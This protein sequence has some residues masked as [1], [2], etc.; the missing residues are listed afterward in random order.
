V[1]LPILSGVYADNASVD[2]RTSYPRN[3][4]PVLSSQG[5]S[6]GYLRPADGVVQWG[7]GPGLSRGG[8]NW[9]GECFRVM[10]TKL[11]RVNSSGGHT[12]IGD[13][14]SG[15]RCS[16]AYSFDR[17]AVASGG[18]LYYWNGQTLTQV[19]D[20]DLGQVLDVTYV[21]GYFMT[22][23]GEFL[24][25]T[26]LNDPTAVD[27]LK[28]GSAELDADPVVRV[29]KVRNEAHAVGRYTTEVYT[30]LGNPG[31]PFIRNE[32]AQIHR[33]A[34]GTHAAIVFDADKIAFLGGGLNEPPAI[35]F[36]GGGTSQKVSTREIDTLLQD[37]TEAQLAAAVLEER[38]D[39]SHKLLLVHLQD[40]TLAFDA[41]AS[42]EAGQAIW[43]TL[44]SGVAEP[45][46][47]RARDLV[48]CFDKWLVADPT[49]TA[50]GY[51]SDT[52]GTHYGAAVGWEFGTQIVYN[53]GR[54]A[55]FYDLELVSLPGGAAL[56]ADPTVWTQYSLDGRS[57]SN[58][59]PAK[60][61][62]QGETLQRILWRRQGLMRNYRMQRFRGTS[63]VRASFARLEASIEGLE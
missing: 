17:L 47:Y 31:F 40:R 19:T 58:L 7:T 50:H 33:G 35:W 44:D 46:P 5:I 59:M 56:G 36:G 8:I 49:S 30:N 11:V 51:L 48:W 14:G 23:D 63:D 21:D 37:Y 22:T 26:E 57:W 38:I 60:A 53:E 6:A 52:V 18:R 25:V 24:I 28:Y 10:G 4:I 13:V 20:P 2:F 9:K 42:G 45:A 27:P 32:G 34:V 15:G 1:Q 55:I 39:K 3:L 16:F 41:Q 43:F 54:R 12:E 61:G 62:K 29:L